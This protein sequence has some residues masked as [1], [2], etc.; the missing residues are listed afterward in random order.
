[1]FK[2][3]E[4]SNNA[5]LILA[6]RKET[7][8]VTLLVMFKVGSRFE[9]RA[10]N[11]VSHFIEHLYFKGTKKRPNT[12]AIS[13]ELDK[14]GAQFNAFTSKD[15]TGY[16][17][18]VAKQHIDLAFDILSDMLFNSKFEAKEINRERGV[19][20]EE[21]RMYR[22]NPSMYIGDL[23]EQI[24]F[25]GHELAREIA[26]PE[27]VIKKISRKEILKYRDEYY[28]ADNMIVGVGGNYSPAKLNK[29]IVKYFGKR[30]G[31]KQD[32]IINPYKDKQK[33]AR[34]K[35][36]YQ[37]T[38]QT[39]LAM[40]FAGLGREDKDYISQLLLSTI[41]GGNMS[42]RL[43]INVRERYGLAYSIRAGIDE[44]VDTGLFYIQ[45][46][47]KKDKVALAYKL[48]VKE[49][50]KLKKL[51]VLDEELNK[52]KEYVKGKMILGL[53]DSFSYVYW[54]SRQLV[55]FNKARTIEQIQK[56]IDKVTAKEIQE[57]AKKIF[58][59][60]KLNLAVIG[61]YKDS[62]YFNKLIK[63]QKI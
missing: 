59:Q 20:I 35:V 54:L 63:Q 26:G 7:D 30:F 39:Q 15:Y 29:L 18:K 43:F 50:N 17:I 9:N 40:G 23:L 8:A 27:S 34:I 13:Q 48:I 5:K 3:K 31:K 33:E 55:D 46:G 2:I 42:S 28:R 10:N 45:A 47:L 56:D 58:T 44:H 37:Q 60:D 38:A 6:P 49:L 32:H 52:A 19:I 4:L 22:D 24:S 1:M 36:Q 14:V 12:D 11:G 51:P 25:K 62:I 21:I 41:L 53:E 16:Y 61:P 57:L